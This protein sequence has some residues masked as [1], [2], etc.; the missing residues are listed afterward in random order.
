MPLP[1]RNQWEELHLEKPQ[2]C[3][4][5]SSFSEVL[6]RFWS[7]T[8]TI[9]FH[10]GVRGCEGAGRGGG[11]L[12]PSFHLSRINIDLFAPL[13]SLQRL[14]KRKPPPSELHQEFLFGCSHRW[15]E[16]EEVEESEGAT[17]SSVLKHCVQVAATMIN[18]LRPRSFISPLTREFTTCKVFI[19]LN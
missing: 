15:E 4:F 11:G 19:W 1:P 7:W 17:H 18:D 14:V 16:A 13:L 8:G 6:K 10:K 12:F 3:H 9:Q 5:F 2:R